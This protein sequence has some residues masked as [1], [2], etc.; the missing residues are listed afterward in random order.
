MTKSASPWL[1]I[2]AEDYEGHMGQGGVGQLSAL[3]RLFAEA[4]AALRPGRLAILGCATGNGFEHVDPKVTRRAVGVDL[5]PR[6]L[7]IARSRHGSLGGVLELICA[8]LEEC[9]FEPASFDL[10]F[11]GLI[12]EYLDPG[13]LVEKIAGWLTPGGAFVAVLQA[14]S[15]NS[16]LVT[17]T[18]FTSLEALSAVMRLVVPAD[19]DR[20][21]RAAGLELVSCSEVSLRFSKKFLVR[22]FER[23]ARARARA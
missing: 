14:A 17:P 8:R 10:I 7:E 19:L 16:P 4:Y 2:P 6:Y 5:N 15:T 20:L 12:F 23:P 9:A 18:G 1:S 11:A 21:A 22:T 13:P 3:S